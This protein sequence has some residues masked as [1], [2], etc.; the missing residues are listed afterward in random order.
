ML[1]IKRFAVMCATALL[2]MGWDFSAIAGNP[3][4]AKPTGRV[5]GCTFPAGAFKP[6]ASSDKMFALASA[7][8][9]VRLESL[10]VNQGARAMWRFPKLTGNQLWDDPN[11]TL[12]A[13]FADAYNEITADQGFS[14]IAS[15]MPYCYAG[16]GNDQGNGFV[17]IPYNRPGRKDV[18]SSLPAIVFL[19][20][21][22]GNLLWNI[23]ALKT[24]FPDHVIIA[25]SGGMAWPELETKTLHTYIQSMCDYVK[26]TFGYEVQ[27]PWLMALSQG[28]PA[29]FRICTTYPAKYRGYVS[30]ASWADG[31][32]RLS[33]DKKLPIL[34]IN[35]TDDE[36]VPLRDASS[37]FET[38]EHRGANIA[39]EKLDD[40]D[41]FFFL[42]QREKMADVIREF[43]QKNEGSYAVHSTKEIRMVDCT[44][45]YTWRD[46]D[47]TIDFTLEADGTFT[48]SQTPDKIVLGEGMGLVT[49]GKGTWSVNNNYLTVTMNRVLSLGIWTPHEVTW[50]NHAT[51][52]KLSG[53][54]IQL[55]ECNALRTQ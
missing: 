14:D 32:D 13:M 30:I 12:V 18:P 11:G 41:H 44:G 51:I 2:P 54:G 48:A 7:A 33:I 24:E 23:W 39:L 36:R 20:G 52:T 5:R 6:E 37:V 25:P 35:G 3:D 49:K 21:Y 42:S 47:R 27:R 4:A 29:G 17:Y 31:A 26:K 53:E 50:I 46:T 9:S 45:K 22:G 40:A 19:H 8:V 10:A 28:G 55:K 43:W 38:L 34:M 1:N 15:A 16:V